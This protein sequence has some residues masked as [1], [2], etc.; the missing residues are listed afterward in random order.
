MQHT[1]TIT[2]NDILE[3][4]YKYIK[5]VFATWIS[6]N[7]NLTRT[8]LIKQFNAYKL[9]SKR[10]NILQKKKPYKWKL[11]RK[12]Q[13]KC[14]QE[15][16]KKIHPHNTYMKTQILSQKNT[17]THNRYPNFK[18]QKAISGS[19]LKRLGKYH[20][21]VSTGVVGDFLRQF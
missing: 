21:L 1:L 19:R 2:R 10:I 12:E 14:E 8:Y 9:K 11:R 13:K 3:Y 16:V 4:N 6:K 5:Y 20:L 7:H 17:K 15:A 18:Q